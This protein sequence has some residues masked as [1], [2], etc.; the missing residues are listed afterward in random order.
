MIL[1]TKKKNKIKEKWK[2]KFKEKKFGFSF[3]W[4][5]CN[6]FKATEHSLFVR[7][8]VSLY[9]TSLL[10]VCVC[11]CFD[12]ASFS[13]LLSLLLLNKAIIIYHLVAKTFVFRNA[14]AVDVLSLVVFLCLSKARCYIIKVVNVVV[15]VV[16]CAV[17]FILV[18]KH[19]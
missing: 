6:T 8:I 4:Q 16:V 10:S 3:H 1:L 9:Y 19:Q 2:L 5:H 14:V 12:V 7:A 17:H 11:V 13:L 18:N 15:V